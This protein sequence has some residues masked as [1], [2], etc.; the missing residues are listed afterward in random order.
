MGHERTLSN[1]IKTTNRKSY[2]Y[3]ELLS[4]LVKVK[5]FEG[6]KDVDSVTNSKLECY[7]HKRKHWTEQD[8]AGGLEATLNEVLSWYQGLVQKVRRLCSLELPIVS[9]T[10]MM[11]IPLRK[12]T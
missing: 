3:S 11:Q 10:P 7:I 9:Y 5:A 6:R 4:S 1:R 12:I 8:L 2:S